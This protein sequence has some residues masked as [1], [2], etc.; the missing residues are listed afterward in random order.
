LRLGVDV[1]SVS[2]VKFSNVENVF[3][4]EHDWSFLD[5]K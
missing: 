2:I 3:C 5:Q 1:E 4:I